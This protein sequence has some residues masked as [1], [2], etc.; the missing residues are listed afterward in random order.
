MTPAEGI[1]ISGERTEGVLAAGLPVRTNA[2]LIR[3]DTKGAAWP[4]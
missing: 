4:I 2:G 3:P 1:T